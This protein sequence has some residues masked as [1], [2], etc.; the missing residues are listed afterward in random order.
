MVRTRDVMKG[1]QRSYSRRLTMFESAGE[2]QSAGVS[3]AG[4]MLEPPAQCAPALRFPSL[5]SVHRTFG[6]VGSV[7]LSMSPRRVLKLVL[8]RSLKVHCSVPLAYGNSLQ[9]FIAGTPVK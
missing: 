1:Y 5:R 6:G 4:L 9:V 8:A 3:G 2:D 7:F